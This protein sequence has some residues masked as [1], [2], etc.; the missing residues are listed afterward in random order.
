MWHNT[1]LLYLL[2]NEVIGVKATMW[3]MICKGNKSYVGNM[4]ISFFSSLCLLKTRKK[5]YVMAI[6]WKE[7]MWVVMF[8][9]MSCRSNS[10]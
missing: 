8:G 4:R 1:L 2:Q 6:W 10:K 9:N 5:T 3:Y 7:V